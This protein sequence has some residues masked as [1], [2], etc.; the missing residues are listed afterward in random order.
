MNLKYL[1]ILLTDRCPAACRICCLQCSPK[2]TFVMDETVMRRYID[3]AGKLGTVQSVGFTGGEAL[4]YPDLLKRTIRYAYET[5]GLP[6]TVVS[7]GFWAA[8]EKKGKALIRELKECGLKGVRLSADLYHQE[9]VPFTTLRK[10]LRILFENGL[11]E[12]ISVMD[13]KGGPNIRAVIE[14]MRPEIYLVP[15]I[16]LYPALLPEITLANEQLDVTPENILTPV[17]WDRCY[18]ED[19]SGVLLYRDGYIYN[20]C[21]QFTVEIPRMRLG[22]IG[23]TTLADALK[24]TNRDPVLEMIRRDSVSWF[25]KKA[26]ELGM[27]VPFR[28][29]VAVSCE[30]CRDL[31]CDRKLMEKLTP[32][33]REEVWKRRMDKLMERGRLSETDQTF[34]Q[35]S[36]RT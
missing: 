26:K 22:K 8:D 31:L 32:L 23:E 18:C 1:S 20:C 17:P 7:N 19:N 28:E 10:A 34:E 13:I 2:N 4:L 21:S 30:L 29:K 3:E 16:S 5:H 33:A 27:D 11:L 6:S 15:K 24:K 25:A 9:Y 14:N 35:G 36:E 12:D